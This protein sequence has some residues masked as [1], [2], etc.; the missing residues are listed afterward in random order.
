MAKCNFSIDFEG[1]IA[2]LIEKASNEII[3]AGGSFNGDINSGSFQIPT[4]LGKVS[5]SYTVRGNAINFEI[6][7]K[8]IVISCAKIEAELR[9]RLDQPAV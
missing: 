1:P 2:P 5:G 3:A 9:K 4:P 6:T 8:P 7:N